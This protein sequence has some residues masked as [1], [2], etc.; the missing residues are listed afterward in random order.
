MYRPKIYSWIFDWVTQCFTMLLFFFSFKINFIIFPTNI[1]S[2]SLQWNKVRGIALIVRGCFRFNN[3]MRKWLT[4][5]SN[6]TFRVSYVKWKKKT[7]MK[8][9]TNQKQNDGRKANGLKIFRSTISSTI[10][11]KC[12]VHDMP[13]V[14]RLYWEEPANC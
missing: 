7:K 9:K 4:K 3:S 13:C 10:R 5:Q 6:S 2:T 14:T 1:R 8:W 12:E 11:I